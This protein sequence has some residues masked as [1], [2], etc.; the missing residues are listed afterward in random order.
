MHF[1]SFCCSSGLRKQLIF[2]DSTTCFPASEEPN[3]CKNS[4]LTAFIT[5]IWVNLR[6]GSIFVSLCNNYF[7]AGKANKT[8]FSGS[9]ST[10]CMRTA[11]I[12]PDLRLDLGRSFDWLKQVSPCGT[13]NY[14]HYPDLGHYTSSVWNFCARFSHVI[15]RGNPT[16]GGISKY[17]LFS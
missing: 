6:S 3:D 8:N 11:K 16:S 1:P 4:T 5:Q 17:R 14:K 15:S 12:G 13:T 2:C 9:R 10:E 7:P